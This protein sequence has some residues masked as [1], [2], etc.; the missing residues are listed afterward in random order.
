MGG[1]LKVDVSLGTM[2]VRIEMHLGSKFMSRTGM[3]KPKL[4][5][6]KPG[7][8]DQSGWREIPESNLRGVRLT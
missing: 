8:G 3:L 5:P 2:L 4:L 6:S 7:L 1:D